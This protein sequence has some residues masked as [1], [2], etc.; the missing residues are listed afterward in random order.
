MV[1]LVGSHLDGAIKQAMKDRKLS[2]INGVRSHGWARSTG[3]FW[4]ACLSLLLL[5]ASVSDA[6]A[7]GS[8]FSNDLSQLEN[9]LFDHDYKNEEDASR[10]D[11]LDKFVFV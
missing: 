7:D 10:I 3:L 1:D 4:G 5:S 11:R 6:R 8:S 9:S 2:A